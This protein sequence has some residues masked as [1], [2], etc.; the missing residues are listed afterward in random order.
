LK[1]K[2]PKILVE[3]LAPDFRGDL[4]LVAQVFR[5]TVWKISTKCNASIDNCRLQHLGLMYLHI[6]SKPLSVFK[7]AFE[8]AGLA[9]L[10]SIVLVVICVVR[11][12]NIF[13]LQSLAV[14]QH[15]K[16]AAPGVLT[17]TSIMLGHGEKQE[18]VNFVCV[19]N[20]RSRRFRVGESYI[21]STP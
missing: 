3:C 8:I 6:T 13:A 21:A 15:A 9:L 20:S 10:R 2:A 14:L 1:E 11:I 12:C 4:D 19:S 17:K 5:F 18:E 16:K 7:G